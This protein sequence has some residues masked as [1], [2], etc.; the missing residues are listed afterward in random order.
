MILVVRI[1]RLAYSKEVNSRNNIYN[2]VRGWR[3]MNVY[4]EWLEFDVVIEITEATKY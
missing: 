1:S 3:L 2:K 4:G